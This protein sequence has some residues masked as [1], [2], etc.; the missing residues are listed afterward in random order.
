MTQKCKLCGRARELDDTCAKGG[1][2]E[3]DV[4]YSEPDGIITTDH[5]SAYPAN[6]PRRRSHEFF[7]PFQRQQS[8][9]HPSPHAPWIRHNPIRRKVWLPLGLSGGNLRNAFFSAQPYVPFKAM[10]LMLWD[11]PPDAV[12]DSFTIC[13]VE[14]VL[15]GSGPLAAQIFARA[16]SYEQMQKLVE[17]SDEEIDEWF[18]APAMTPA[19]R[20]TL[21]LSS[22]LGDFS[23]TQA[24]L[25]GLGIVDGS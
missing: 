17:E 11:L 24:A 16:G 12:V 25:W 10:G 21:Q 14:V 20:A 8:S 22:A 1:R 7:Q 13:N 6:L 15:A 4:L 19:N 9:A 2:C 18:D 23:K 5:V 3:Y